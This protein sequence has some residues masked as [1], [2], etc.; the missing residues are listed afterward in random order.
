MRDIR[1]ERVNVSGEVEGKIIRRKIETA[2]VPY[3]S[4]SDHIMV[5]RSRRFCRLVKKESRAGM[6]RVR[7]RARARARSLVY[8]HQRLFFRG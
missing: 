3:L 6:L 5:G 4:L 7:A 2:G 8:V 1:R